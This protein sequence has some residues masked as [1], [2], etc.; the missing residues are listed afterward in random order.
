MIERSILRW[1]AGMMAV[2]LLLVGCS[3]R[4]MRLLRP[5]G[6]AVEAD[7]SVVIMDRGNYDVV[8]GGPEGH[9]ERAFGKLGKDA[10]DIYSGWD[11]ALDR[12][13][14]I[15]ICNL[16]RNELADT[17][18]DGVKVFSPTGKFLREIGAQS[19]EAGAPAND[20]YGLDIDKRDWV[21]VADFHGGTVRVFDAEGTLLETFFD[22]PEDAPVTFKGINDVA[23]DDQRNLVY[24]VDSN[25]GELQQ[26]SLKIADNKPRLTY[27]QTIGRYGRGAEEFAY[28]QY[29]TVDESRDRVY[30]SDMANRRIQVLEAKGNFLGSWVPDLA[31]LQREGSEAPD[32]QV[33][34]LGVGPD[35][36]LYAA[37]AWN[38][39]I[40]VFDVDGECLGTY[41][42]GR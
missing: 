7:G 29:V 18:H 38:S 17:L 26:F 1:G 30:V 9:L 4:E 40:W 31:M 32:W 5:N 34:G 22:Q 11:I 14:N 10:E 27:L 37:D 16:V 3:S 8:V 2:G 33:M 28:P 42:V 21:Y 19:Y 39:V 15:Y 36:K 13:G 35:G 20:P 24:V 25:A 23:V 6:V 41:E 12:D